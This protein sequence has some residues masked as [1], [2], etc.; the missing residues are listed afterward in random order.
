MTTP[1]VNSVAARQVYV[2]AQN[3][4]IALIDGYKWGGGLGAGVNLTYSFPTGTAS[5]VSGYE[6][7]SGWFAITLTESL[8]VTAALK[9]VISVINVNVTKV[10]DNASVV[11]DIRFAVTKVSGPD[12]AAHAFLPG[13]TPEGGDVWFSNVNWNENGGGISRGDFDFSTAMHEIGHALGL[14]HTFE[15]PNI[16]PAEFDN[17][18]YTVMSYTASPW[19]SR[20]DNYASFYPTTLMYYD[21]LALQTLYGR[22]RDHNAGNTRYT[23]EQGRTYFQT[24]DD[25]GGLDTIQYNGTRGVSIDLDEGGFSNVSN[26]VSFSGGNASR[27]TVWIGPNT[28]IERATG[29]SGADTL[30]GNSARNLLSGR[31]GNDTLKGWGGADVLFGG[32]GRDTLVGGTG[33]DSFRFASVAETGITDLTRDRIL[34][35]VHLTDKINVA[36]IDPNRAVSG[37]DDFNWRG[38]H[39]FTLGSE[40]QLRY[41][42]FDKPGKV[43]DRTIIFGDVDNDTGAEFQIELKGLINL[44]REDILL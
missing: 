8:G 28:V 39:A 33:A 18:F 16:L 17:Y 25:A 3:P 7:F 20:G 34:D 38:K 24:I 6:E 36:V 43:D 27:D 11:G 37:D 9:E 15:G 2:S 30:L 10:Q 22:D 14:K 12:E 40:G 21:I 26:A 42:L 29:G 13:N 23:F 5:F 32:I 44:T 1:L 31:S 35:F 19:S 4:A 41:Q